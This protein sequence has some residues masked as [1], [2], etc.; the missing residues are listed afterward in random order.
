MEN[1]RFREG[2][3]YLDKVILKLNELKSVKEIEIFSVVYFNCSDTS[4][5]EILMSH[6]RVKDIMNVSENKLERENITNIS[7]EKWN[8]NKEEYY[9]KTKNSFVIE[10]QGELVLGGNLFS[11]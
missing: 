6:P 10:E 7:P 1:K 5:L 4:F 8:K 11:S 2:L 9:Q 3:S